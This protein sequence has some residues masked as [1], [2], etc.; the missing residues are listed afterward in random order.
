MSAAA[1]PVRR[2]A[3]VAGRLLAL[4]LVLLLLGLGLLLA[5]ATEAQPR[6]TQSDALA[7]HDVERALRLARTHDPR[8][9]L[10]GVL[11][12]LTLTP[13]EAEVLLNH[14]AARL[15]ASR[16][17][18]EAGAERLRVRGS[19]PL[20]APLPGRWANVELELHA[21]QALPRLHAARLGRLVLP[22]P[23][24]EW[25]FWRWAE[26][27]GLGGREPV[28]VLRQVLLQ[29]RRID[30]QYAWG[31]DAPARLM[32]ALLP[33]GEHE[34]LRAYAARLAELASTGEPRSLSEVLPPM[35]ELARRRSAGGQSA[36]LEN[37]AALM[38][39]GMVANGI[40]LGTLLPERRAELAARPLRLTLA[41]RSDFPQHLLVSAALA[42]DGGTPLADL[43]GLYKELADA[44]W[45]SGFSFNDMAANRAGAR[46]GTLAISDPGRLQGRLAVPLQEG[47]FMPD[48]AGLPEFLSER[49]FRSRYGSPGSPAYEQLMNDIEQRLGATPLFRP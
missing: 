24:V 45:G 43:L 30:L 40:G 9:A 1:S 18:L 42:A 22:S 48:T 31:P 35:F 6:V 15:L 36:A 34:R 44:R 49:E 20:A 17:R 12:T 11:R 19:L 47:D 46:L 13:H 10:P 3:R 5:L 7:V 27:H 21:T 23:L 25:L 16:W 38:V 41:G 26:A 33:A 28:L 37:R 4:L 14:A 2:A 8:R 39:L 32:P 29:P